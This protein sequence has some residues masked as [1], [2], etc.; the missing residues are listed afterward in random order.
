MGVREI[1]AEKLGRRLRNLDNDLERLKAR[2]D[3]ALMRVE[4]D[5]YMTIKSLRT[6]EE[7]IDALLDQLRAPECQ[8]LD[9]LKEKIEDAEDDLEQA[10]RCAALKLEVRIDP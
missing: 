1:Y 4:D 10:I 5:H 9:E 8:A 3:L 6:F 7:R 2:S